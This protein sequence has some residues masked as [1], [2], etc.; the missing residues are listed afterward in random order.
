MKYKVGDR[1]EAVEIFGPI[2]QRDTGT[3]REVHDIGTIGVEW[4]KKIADDFSW[5]GHGYYVS[6]WILRLTEP[7][8]I[9]AYDLMKLAA[10]NPQEYKGK[11]YEVV[12]LGAA[13]IDTC[14][15]EHKVITITEEGSFG[16]GTLRL[17]VS[18]ITE[19]IE[20]LP[21]PKPV[22]F[23]EARKVY[24]EGKII[25]A[26]YPGFNDGQTLTV[27]YW[28]SDDGADNFMPSDEFNCGISF[29][30][31]RTAKWYIEP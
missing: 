14:G 13:A 30:I 1:V 8:P 12:G 2:K 28:K 17:Y 11:R 27:K 20:I 4:D 6:E 9:H 15:H 31:I 7:A 21:E 25:I 23:D 19:L 10:E 29:Y 3:V 26:K 24:E 5:N 16:D 22:S 18:N